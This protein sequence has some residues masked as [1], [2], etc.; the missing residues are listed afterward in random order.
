VHTEAKLPPSDQKNYLPA[1]PIKIG[2]EQSRKQ[3][4]EYLQTIRRSNST[5]DLA[6]YAYRDMETCDWEPFIKAAVERN[7]VSIQMADSMSVDEVY[8][9]LA[10]MKST[11]IY[12]GKRLAQPDEVANYQTGDGLEKAFLLANIIHQRSPEQDIEITVDNNDVTLKERDEY[13]F[14]SD[15]GFKSVISIPAENKD[16]RN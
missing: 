3:I 9:W 6:L 10:K 7:P 16:Y 14:V 15:K 5:A 12:E 1:D 8:R 13:R 4:I 2:V 11:S